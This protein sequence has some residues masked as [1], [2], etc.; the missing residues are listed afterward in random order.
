MISSEHV[1]YIISFNSHTNP[2]R[3][4]FCLI[5]LLQMD[6]LRWELLN[7]LPKVTQLVSLV[8]PDWSQNEPKQY[9]Q[10]SEFLHLYWL[11]VRKETPRQKPKVMAWDSVE[12]Y[13]FEGFLAYLS[14]TWFSHLKKSP[15]MAQIVKNLPAVQETLFD[16]WIRKIPRRR[17]W[18]STPVFL[19][20][21]SRGQRILVGHSPWGRKESMTEWL[22]L[23]LGFLKI[24]VFVLVKLHEVLKSGRAGALRK[25]PN[26][27]ESILSWV[28][29]RQ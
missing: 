20:G 10:D 1:I 9:A 4:M 28:E 18:Q 22:T 5:L 7:D 6:T 2:V 24:I 19:P 14:G 23:L 12:L 8:E 17:A 3:Y 16:P 27:S 29:W 21:E 13:G 15:I 25:S 11:L 26:I